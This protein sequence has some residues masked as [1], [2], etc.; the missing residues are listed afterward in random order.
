V[1]PGP[2]H[3]LLEV[4][5]RIPVAAGLLFWMI[6]SVTAY[7][8]IVVCSLVWSERSTLR[9]CAPAAFAVLV[10]LFFIAEQVGVGGNIPFYDRYMLQLGPFLG[11]IGFWL[12]PSFT[13]SRILTLAGLALLSYG[14][15]W[16]YAFTLK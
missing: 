16:R 11:V 6:A 5:S 10:V 15:L 7:N 12:F 2:L 3:S 14:M 8:F 9:A 4:A 13:R 1:N